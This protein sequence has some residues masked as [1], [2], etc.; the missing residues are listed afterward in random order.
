MLSTLI[1]AQSDGA[2][3]FCVQSATG[4]VVEGVAL[5]AG[6]G[7]WALF[8]EAAE[9]KAMAVSCASEG[10]EGGVWKKS[11]GEPKRGNQIVKQMGSKIRT[12]EN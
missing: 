3:G 4:V 5:P 1:T 2:D 8:E 11:K 10:V 7:V 6:D 12:S 9:D